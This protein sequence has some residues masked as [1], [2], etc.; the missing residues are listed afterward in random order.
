MSVNRRMIEHREANRPDERIDSYMMPIEQLVRYDGKRFQLEFANEAMS[1]LPKSDERLARPSYRG[2]LLE[3]VNEAVLDS[4]VDLLRDVY[5]ERL[6]VFA[7]AVR[8]V[9]DQQVLQPNMHLRVNTLRAYA[10]AVRRDV[11]MRNSIILDEELRFDGYMIRA[12]APLQS[13]LGHAKHL[14]N[15]TKGNASYW[16]WLSHYAPKPPDD[17]GGSAA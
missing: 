5:G 11:A 3:A 16:S 6:I 9:I 1:W 8:C 17:G 10:G 12:T 14:Q 13:L 7:P 4:A 15:I 2:L